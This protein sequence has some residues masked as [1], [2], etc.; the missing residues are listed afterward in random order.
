MNGI[1]DETLAD[2]HHS[3]RR[4]NYL[5]N[6]LGAKSYLEVGVFKGRTFKQIIAEAKYAVDPEFRFKYQE[7]SKPNEIY[8]NKISD[9]F[10][11][12]L[13]AGKKL[14]IVFL[15]GLHTFRQ[16]YRDFCN[17]LAHTHDQSIILID[18]TLPV[19]PF[20]A[21]NDKARSKSMR[22]ICN[23]EH[24][25][26]WHGDVYKLVFLIHDF[27]PAF[28]YG[29]IQEPGNPQTVVWKSKIKE[30]RNPIF[31]DLEVISRLSYFDL[32]DNIQ[33]LKIDTEANVLNRCISS[34]IPDTQ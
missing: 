17:T 5:I 27:Y 10:F 26:A 29:T 8:F 6:K 24:T 22:K 31:D 1:I 20:S 34:L 12:S 23:A 15:D 13:D 19:D 3:V 14:D 33:V 11:R 4:L 25:K 28:S 16:T 9:D 2:S 21:L 32:I 18:D 30:K 7:R